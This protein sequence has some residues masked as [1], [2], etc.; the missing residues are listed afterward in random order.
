MFASLRDH[1]H[2]KDFLSDDLRQLAV[3]R[4]GEAIQRLARRELLRRGEHWESSVSLVQMKDSTSRAELIP[5]K[6]ITCSCGAKYRIKPEHAGKRLKCTKCG[7]VLG[8]L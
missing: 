7:K 8:R 5:A 3:T 6:S 2:V 1:E 4:F